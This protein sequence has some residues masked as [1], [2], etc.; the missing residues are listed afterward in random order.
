VQ[1]QYFHGVDSDG[2]PI[3]IQHLG[4]IDT[5]ELNR[6]FPIERLKLAL[7]VSADCVLR[8]RFPACSEKAGRPIQVRHR[9]LLH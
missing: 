1:P 4:G 3:Y 7:A 2:R 5:S 6:V 8:E 9:L